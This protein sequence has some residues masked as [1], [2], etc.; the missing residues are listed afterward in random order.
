MLRTEQARDRHTEEH[1]HE[2]SRGVGITRQAGVTDRIR[3]DMAQ[4]DPRDIQLLQDEHG[5][6]LT[7]VVVQRACYISSE[8]EVEQ[9]LHR[10]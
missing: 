2:P 8:E 5:L 1:K 10:C 9:Q 3:D 6:R 7:L 4:L